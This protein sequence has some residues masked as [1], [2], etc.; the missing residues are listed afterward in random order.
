MLP[1]IILGRRTAVYVGWIAAWVLNSHSA[2]GQA[3]DAGVEF[4][5]KRIRPVLVEH[6]Y[7]C[8]SSDA[9]KIKGDF[10]LDSRD[11]LLKG[12]E[13][14][15]AIVPGKAAESLLIKAVRYNTDIRMPPKGKLPA[16]AIADLEAWSRSAQ[17]DPRRCQR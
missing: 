7:S 6:C 13:S 2:A 14:G 8:H 10:R 16:A 9:K 3:N 1:P 17:P 15:P 4:F 11:A 5:E 12:G